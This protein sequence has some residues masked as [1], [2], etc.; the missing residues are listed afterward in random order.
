MNQFLADFFES[1]IPLDFW[2]KI[3]N[4][5]HSETVKNVSHSSWK[6]LGNGSKNDSDP[7]VNIPVIDKYFNLRFVWFGHY[8]NIGCGVSKGGIQH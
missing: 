8:G 1:K 5:G 7:I 3:Q 4:F 2:T 6:F